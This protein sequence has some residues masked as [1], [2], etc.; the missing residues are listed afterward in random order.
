MLFPP[1][2][3]L[4]EDLKNEMVVLRSDRMTAKVLADPPLSCSNEWTE[5]SEVV[6]S[7]VKT[8][9]IGWRVRALELLH[10]S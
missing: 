9:V 6:L 10:E 7:E 2:S 3:V 1:F 8:L 5:R 4:S